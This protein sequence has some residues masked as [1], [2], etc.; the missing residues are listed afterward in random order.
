M[1][2]LDLLVFAADSIPAI[3]AI[4]HDTFAVFPSN[5]FA[6]RALRAMYFALA[7]LMRL[8]QFL[9]YGLALILAFIDGKI[10]LEQ[11]V[12]MV[13]RCRWAPWSSSCC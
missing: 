6:L 2:L 12:P 4:T 13:C 1:L 9:N 5:V 10:L 3:P 11:V 7:S 8:F